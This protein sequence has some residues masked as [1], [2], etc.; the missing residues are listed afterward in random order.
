MMNIVLSNK[1]TSTRKKSHLQ[2]R[3][4]K[5]RSQLEKQRRKNDRFMAELDELVEIHRSHSQSSDGLQIDELKSLAEKLVTFASRKTLSDWHRDELM[6]WI[7]ELMGRIG[8]IEPAVAARL[9]DSYHEAVAT[10]MGMSVEDMEVANQ[11]AQA[12]FEKVFEDDFEKD[13][14]PPFEDED[15]DDVSFQEDLFGFDDFFEEQAT[16]ADGGHTKGPEF[17]F[18]EEEPERLS[19][20]LMDE[21][22]IKHLFRRAA[23]ALHPDREQNPEIRRQKQHLMSKLLKARK[24][25]DIM[26]LLSIYSENVDDGDIV[27]AERDMTL[28]CE[29]L[30]E[31]LEDLEVKKMEYAYSNPYRSMVHDLLY[32]PSKKRRNH[33]VQEW[34]KLLEVDADLIRMMVNQL[35][36]L[37]QL[38]NTLRDR[39]DERR[40]MTG[41]MFSL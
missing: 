36:N 33:N 22:W 24:Q 25:G 17:F 32:A 20:Q 4:E 39:R 9:R 5:L 19:A 1:A 8:A 16:A 41:L 14:E 35:R 29:M 40:F 6:N 30:E 31:E 13:F 27:I 2:T 11:A 28:V 15:E 37:T 34:K 38:K 7:V 26:M 12:A 3:F 21:N 18:E 10:A 23:Q